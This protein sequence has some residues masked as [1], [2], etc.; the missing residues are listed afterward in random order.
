M[1][2]VLRADECA[3]KGVKKG[4]K[5]LA[6]EVSVASAMDADVDGEAFKYS[7]KAGDALSRDGVKQYLLSL[8]PVVQGLREGFKISVAER[9]ED[10]LLSLAEFL[11]GYAAKAGVSVTP[12]RMQLTEIP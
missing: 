4:G 8:G 2:C 1:V 7:D 6:V 10:P 3:M 5:G 12:A 11:R 9:P